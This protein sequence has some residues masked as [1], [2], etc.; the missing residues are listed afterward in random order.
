M[1]LTMTSEPSDLITEENLFTCLRPLVY[2]VDSNLSNI[3]NIIADIEIGGTYRFTQTLPANATGG[4][5]FKIQDL[6]QAYLMDRLQGQTAYGSMPTLG[7]T[8]ATYNS[9]R[10]A[11]TVQVKFFEQTQNVTTGLL[12]TDWDEDGAGTPVGLTSTSINVVCVPVQK[13]YDGATAY[14]G[15]VYGNPSTGNFRGVFFNRL[16]GANFPLCLPSTADAYLHGYFF[17]A[18]AARCRVRVEE[19]DSSG[20]TLA[21]S[22]LFTAGSLGYCIL[23]VGPAAV[24]SIV[25]FNANTDTYRVYSEYDTDGAGAWSRNTDYAYYKIDTKCY[26]WSVVAHFLCANGGMDTWHIGGERDQVRVFEEAPLVR[27]LM[28]DTIDTRQRDYFKTKQRS[29]DVFAV[30][31]AGVQDEFDMRWITDLLASPQVFI[32]QSSK[33][34]AALIRSPDRRRYKSDREGIFDDVVIN[35]ELYPLQ[36]VKQ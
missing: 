34:Y 6:V 3:V 19:F 16:G 13:N 27:K 21:T 9:D 17:G 24:D 31:L 23:P 14:I 15:D 2:D 1:A 11:G 28:E 26:R 22:T 5:K 32:D 25:T 30:E 36:S 35:Y 10:W 8:T 29:K 18:T 12:E 33:R 7:S 20:S 4:A